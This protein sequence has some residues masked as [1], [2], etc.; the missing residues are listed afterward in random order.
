MKAL[1]PETRVGLFTIAAGIA[2]L[3]ISL[4]TAGVSLFGIE[5]AFSFNMNF[6]TVAGVELRSK[7]KLSG[8]EIGYIEDIIL[9]EGHATVKARLVREAAIRRN[10]MATIRTSGLLGE[11][12]IEIIQGTQDQPLLKDG[13]TLENTREPADISDII[14]K[15]GEVMDDVKAV[16]ASLK[17][18]FGTLEAEKTLKSILKN[19][20]RASADMRV[21]L[22]ENKNSLKITL[23]NFSIIST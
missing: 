8:V 19:I 15:V 7:V 3:Y 13:E 23:D 6:D 14:S 17:S 2:L 1:T 18:I 22:A 21:I 10:A 9:E 12:Y 16:T 11:Q 5:D 4:K 20:D